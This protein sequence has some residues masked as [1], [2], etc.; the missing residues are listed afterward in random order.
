M[1]PPAP[2]SSSK[3]A[4]VAGIL[5][6]LLAAGLGTYYL[7]LQSGHGRHPAH[8]TRA[9][10]QP[11]AA[12]DHSDS[13]PEP[14]PSPA[15]HAPAPAHAEAAAGAAQGP[16]RSKA[17]AALA[18]LALPELKAWSARIEQ[19]SHGQLHGAV[20]EDDPAPLVVDGKRYW[21]F[22]FVA[23]GTDAASRWDSFLVAEQG[24]EILVED[25]ASDDLLSLDQ[26][27]QQKQPMAR[28]G[29]P[30]LGGG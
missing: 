25:A 8:A 18:L 2:R 20:I 29:G 26:W 17:Q 6:G 27:R 5:A 19:Q 10:V 16:L 11:D 24:D 3:T 14:A 23:N 12:P 15:G 13:T 9:A 30:G 4:I 22:S 7:H 28:Q 21:Q 1:A